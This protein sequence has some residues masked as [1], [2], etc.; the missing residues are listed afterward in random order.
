MAATGT[1]LSPASWRFAIVSKSS[2]N[3]L[4]L[5]AI[6]IF[7]ITATIVAC[8]LVF[9]S[10]WFVDGIDVSGLLAADYGWFRVAEFRVRLYPGVK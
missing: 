5:L 4:P 2:L 9:I 1:A 3:S 10:D 7:V 6:D 8:R